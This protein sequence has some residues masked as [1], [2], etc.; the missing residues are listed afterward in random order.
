MTLKAI[1]TACGGYTAVCTHTVFQ[2]SCNKWIWLHHWTSHPKG[3]FWFR[4]LIFTLYIQNASLRILHW[5]NFCPTWLLCEA[6]GITVQMWL[7]MGGG[8][9]RCRRS[10]T[11]LPEFWSQESWASCSISLFL[12]IKFSV[13]W[14]GNYQF[15][16]NASSSMILISLNKPLN[17]ELS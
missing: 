7:H 9:L 4:E 10:R 1:T 13:G 15:P 14:S 17:L 16:L 12:N 6:L 5:Q 3:W 11:P 8:T 2:V